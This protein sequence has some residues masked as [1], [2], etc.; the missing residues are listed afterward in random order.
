MRWNCW[1]TKPIE[2]PRR[3]ERVA[4]SSLLTS[5]P[6]MRIVPDVGR[7]STPSSPS[8]VDLP[9]P[10]GPTIDMKSPGKICSD[11]SRNA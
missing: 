4:S 10:D 11:T 1:N 7:S 6:A 8:I 5:W 3:R 2:S 9:E